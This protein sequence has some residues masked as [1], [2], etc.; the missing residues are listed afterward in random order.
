[1]KLR[2]CKAGAKLRLT[3]FA[4]SGRQYRQKLLSMG[5][6]KGMELSVLRAAPLGDPVEI[7][8]GQ[9]NV[10]LRRDEADAIEV[11]EIRS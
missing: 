6:S 3:A 9:S 1:M 2:E 10:S 7:R 5:F 8:V 11:E 4:Q